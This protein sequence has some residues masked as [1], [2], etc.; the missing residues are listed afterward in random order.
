MQF[1]DFCVHRQPYDNSVDVWSLGVITYILLCGFSPFGDDQIQ[2]VFMNVMAAK[3]EFPSPEW[4][5]VSEDAKNFIKRI[6]V[7]DPKERATPDHLLQDPWIT[8]NVPAAAEAATT[9]VE[10][11]QRPTI[12]SRRLASVRR[13][14]QR[15]EVKKKNQVKKPNEDTK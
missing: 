3:Y 8:K 12:A 7:I 1:A 6:F 14:Q 9:E 13:I 11:R 5:E 10:P 15:Q 2:N 4:D